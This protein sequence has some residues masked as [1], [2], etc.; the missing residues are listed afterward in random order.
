MEYFSLIVVILAC[1]FFV[2]LF[3]KLFAKFNVNQKTKTKIQYHYN[4]KSY[5]MTKRE[6]DFFKRLEQIF[7]QKFYI[8]PQVHL[9]AILD[10]KVKNQNW[11]AALN[12]IQRK[13]IDYVFYDKQTMML[14]FAIELDDSTHDQLNRQKRDQEVEMILKQAGIKLIRFRNINLSDQEIV[15]KIAQIFK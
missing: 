12:K 13:S 10:H 8:F 7:G 9:D 1:L 14:R 15:S 6:N 5:L 2:W 11:K 4:K 3:K